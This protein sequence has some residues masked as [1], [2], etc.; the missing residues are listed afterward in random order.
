M[1]DALDLALLNLVDD[2][3]CAFAT[4][5]SADD[6]ALLCNFEGF[7]TL[8]LHHQVELFLLFKPLLLEQFVLLQLF[9]TDRNHF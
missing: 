5:L 9:V 6:F 3:E 2:D 4:G 8:D 7:E 1:F